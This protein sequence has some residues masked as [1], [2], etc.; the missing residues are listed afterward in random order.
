MK[1]LSLTQPLLLICEG[2]QL[3]LRHIPLDGIEAGDGAAVPLRWLDASQNQRLHAQCHLR[4]CYVK[5]AFTFRPRAFK[6]PSPVMCASGG[7]VA[8]RDRAKNRLLA[9]DARTDNASESRVVYLVTTNRQFKYR[10]LSFVSRAIFDRTQHGRNFKYSEKCASDFKR[11]DFSRVDGYSTSATLLTHPVESQRRVAFAVEQSTQPHS[12]FPFRFWRIVAQAVKA[13]R[14]IT[15][16][17]K[18]IAAFITFWRHVNSETLFEGIAKRLG[19]LFIGDPQAENSRTPSVAFNHSGKVC[20]N[21]HLY[22]F[23]SKTDCVHFTTLEA[24]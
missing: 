12:H 23:L 17:Y 24:I 16:P 15:D 6:L 11:E 14:F 9:S 3:G 10:F 7:L 20:N 13:P 2:D 8:S 21:S 19:K 1:A 4:H 22:T 5:G 18:P